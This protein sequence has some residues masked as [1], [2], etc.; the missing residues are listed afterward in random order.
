MTEVAI[1]FPLS[2]RNAKVFSDRFSEGQTRDINGGFPSDTLPYTDSYDYL[3]DSDLEDESSSF[4]ESEEPSEGYKPGQP[5]DTQDPLS[6]VP[7]TTAPENPRQQDP[8]EDE[9]HNKSVLNSLNLNPLPFRANSCNRRDNGS[10][11]MGKVAF[12]RDMAAVTCA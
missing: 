3:S 9:N 12:I 10:A 1:V 6:Q 4:G 2:Q 8:G 5:R 11:R 7:L